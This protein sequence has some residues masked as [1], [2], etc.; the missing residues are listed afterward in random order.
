[1]P[2]IIQY[3]DEG[4]RDLATLFD[5]EEDSANRAAVERELIAFATI[6]TGLNSVEQEMNSFHIGRPRKDARFATILILAL[7]WRDYRGIPPSVRRDRVE[8][9]TSGKF[10]DLVITVLGEENS[11][12]DRDIYQVCTIMKRRQL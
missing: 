5:I 6:R 3:T 10:R 4:V 1:M 2:R 8:D 9:K 7:M 12:L 11:G